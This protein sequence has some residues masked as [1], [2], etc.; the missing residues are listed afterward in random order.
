MS[1]P[2]PL[3]GAIRAIIHHVVALSLI[4]LCQLVGTLI[5]LAIT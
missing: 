2:S 4:G 3:R 1:A 5:S